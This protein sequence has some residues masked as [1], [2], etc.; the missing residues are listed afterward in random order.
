MSDPEATIMTK[1][2]AFLSHFLELVDADELLPALGP[3]PRLYFGTRG[4]GAM[5]VYPRGR[6]FPPFKFLF[7][8]GQLMIAGCWKGGFGTAG[9]RDMPRLH[10]YWDKTTLARRGRSLLRLS[11]RTRFG[12]SERTSPVRSTIQSVVNC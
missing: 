9:D 4:G 11:I 10:R 1:L 6:R 8:K 7:R 2:T 12:R 3:A 5:F